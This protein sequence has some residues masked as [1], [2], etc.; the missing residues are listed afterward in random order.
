[1]KTTHLV[2]IIYFSCQKLVTTNISSPIVLKFWEVTG[3]IAQF[4]L[5][6]VLFCGGLCVISNQVD[7]NNGVEIVEIKLIWVHHV[8]DNEY[9]TTGYI[10]QAKKKNPRV[11]ANQRFIIKIIGG[12][13]LVN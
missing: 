11:K 4:I 8:A 12:C 7:G 13:C 6:P 9:V 5:V 1:M 2:Y 3:Q 10:Y